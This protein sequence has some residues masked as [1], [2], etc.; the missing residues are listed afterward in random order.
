MPLRFANPSP[1]SG[2]IEDFHLQ[3]VRS[4]L[5]TP[6]KGPAGAVPRVGSRVHFAEGALRSSAARQFRARGLA[7]Q[8]KES[9]WRGEFR[10]L[11]LAPRGLTGLLNPYAKSG[12][13]LFQPYFLND[14]AAKF[15]LACVL[16]TTL[17]TNV[18]WK[19]ACQVHV[20]LA[21]FNRHLPA[22]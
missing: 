2:W 14:G 6:R 19:N 5:G 21:A 9:R 17:I 10:R 12:K 18:C 16:F 22:L 7:P 3:A 13:R 1:P 20:S 8:R 11:V 4:I 15:P